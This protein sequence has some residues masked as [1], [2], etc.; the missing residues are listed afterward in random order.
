ML[1]QVI[2]L[3]LTSLKAQNY[4]LQLSG[5][6]ILQGLAEHSKSGTRHVM[7]SVHEPFRRYFHSRDQLRV[8]SHGIL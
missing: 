5:V 2:Q 4:Q 1:L 6:A 8:F 3:A 7:M